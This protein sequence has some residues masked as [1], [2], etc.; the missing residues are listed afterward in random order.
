MSGG[1]IYSVGLSPPLAAASLKA[2]E[3]LHKSPERVARL[4]KNSEFFAK[5]ARTLGLDIGSSE[6]H[7]VIPIILH[8]SILAVALSQKLFERGINVQPI[9]HPAVPERCAR[10]RFF[11]TS[12]H[13]KVQIE[14]TCRAIAEELKLIGDGKS[15]LTSGQI[16][17]SGF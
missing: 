4:R 8:N 16:Q 5:C 3:L 10:L 17:A 9:I 1:F 15:I 13:T 7:A 6:G 12:E 2:L 14:S 11:V